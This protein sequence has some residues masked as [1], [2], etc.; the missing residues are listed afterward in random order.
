MESI[1]TLQGTEIVAIVTFLVLIGGYL[2]GFAKLIQKLELKPD[3]KEVE[4][5]IEKKFENHCPFV[6]KIVKIEMDVKEIKI[7]KDDRVE[8]LHRVEKNLLEVRLNVK[9]I[10]AKLDVEYEQ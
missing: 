6:D 10:C 2:W 7:W 9:Q 8:L 4:D 5:M 1:I 3:I